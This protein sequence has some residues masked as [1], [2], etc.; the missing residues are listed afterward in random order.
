[1]ISHSEMKAVKKAARQVASGDTRL[2]AAGDRLVKAAKEENK[3][4]ALESKKDIE[5]F[6]HD[7]AGYIV[8]KARGRI[9]SFLSEEGRRNYD[10]IKWG[11]QHKRDKKSC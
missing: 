11:K 10:R 7:T 8:S 1:M 3:K 9:T 6:S 2:K 4:R 5:S